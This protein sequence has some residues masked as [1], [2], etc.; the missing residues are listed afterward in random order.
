[1]DYRLQYLESCFEKI[2][3]KKTE[4]YV[5]Q[6]IWNLLH[7]DEV[8]IVLQQFVKLRSSGYAL[9]DLYFPQIRIAVE[10]NE[11]FHLG[12]KEKDEKR[13]ESVKNSM[14]L[15]EVY[16]IDCSQ[17]LTCIHKQV[18]NL[19]E[20]IKVRISCARKAGKFE[21]WTGENEM[22]FGYYKKRGYL[23]V[24]SEDCFENIDDICITFNTKA[25]HRGYLRAGGA[26]I[27]GYP[28]WRLW[29]PN[30][31]GSSWK[32]EISENGLTIRE[33]PVDNAKS[34]EHIYRCTHLDE[35]RITFLK[36]G[37]GLYHF[38]GVF[39]LD[40]EATKTEGKTVW[41]RVDTKICLNDL[42]CS[43]EL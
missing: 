20:T 34:E 13:L 28:G 22:S 35:T 36:R 33:Y 43:N 15:E 27:P 3:H 18:D 25:V 14:P 6:R 8:K 21:A 4:S 41:E 19:V 26:T 9:L 40:K 42:R 10:I 24:L 17:P 11:P 30:E 37:D 5:I 1:M 12:T 32:N 16:V 2:Q 23:S 7:D 31:N 38:V 39:K 29:F